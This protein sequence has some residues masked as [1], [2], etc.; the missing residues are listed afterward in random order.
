MRF[1]RPTAFRPV[2]QFGR[3]RSYVL[4]LPQPPAGLTDDLKLF[5]LTFAGGLVFMSIYLG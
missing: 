3:G 5:G 4:S 1:R 2:T